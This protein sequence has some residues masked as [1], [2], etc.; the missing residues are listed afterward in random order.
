MPRP[1]PS[2]LLVLAA[3]GGAT[4]P[5]NF[6]GWYEVETAT[7][8][9]CDA[10]LEP[11]DRP[12]HLFVEEASD[13]YVIRF[14]EGSAEDDCYARPFYDFVTSIDDGWAADGGSATYSAGCSLS[15]AHATAVLDGDTLTVHE[16]SYLVF[17]FRPQEECT[18]EIALA[19]EEPCVAEIAVTATH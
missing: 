11:A 8:G 1:L 7:Q 9:A 4:G 13:G 19:L 16:R 2:L 6:D 14:C 17:D 18:E 5:A 15:A 12:T 3:C 10:D